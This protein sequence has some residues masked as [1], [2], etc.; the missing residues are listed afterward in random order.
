MCYILCCGFW[1]YNFGHVYACEDS[2]LRCGSLWN[3]LFFVHKLFLGWC[4]QVNLGYFLQG[5]SSCSVSCDCLDKVNE[6]KMCLISF[7]LSVLVILF[8]FFVDSIA[9]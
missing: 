3:L 6:K 9:Y 2:G 7:S 5:V 8:R 1:L 4:S